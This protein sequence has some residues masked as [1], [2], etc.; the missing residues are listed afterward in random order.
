MPTNAVKSA[1]DISHRLARSC[2][3]LKAQHCVSRQRLARAPVKRSGPLLVGGRSSFEVSCA[4]G[5]RESSAALLHLQEKCFQA[6]NITVNAMVP[7]FILKPLWKGRM[8]NASVSRPV[9]SD[10][11]E[12]R[13]C[14]VSVL[15][16]HRDWQVPSRPYIRLVCFLFA[17]LI[18]DFLAKL[19]I[20]VDLRPNDA[21]MIRMSACVLIDMQAV[22]EFADVQSFFLSFL[23][24]KSHQGQ[25]QGQCQGQGWCQGQGQVS[26]QG[27]GQFSRSWKRIR[28]RLGTQ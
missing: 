4:H 15:H 8:E 2:L 12:S 5:P 28:V 10:S 27:Q 20:Y 17:R 23:N 24:F 7:V 26:G 19:I 9:C 13:M 11:D 3:A 21:L 1:D 22:R 25:R 16:K 6:W 18:P 14:V